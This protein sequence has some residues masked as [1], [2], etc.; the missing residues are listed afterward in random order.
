MK[1]WRV[2]A[3]IAWPAILVLLA[4]F[5]GLFVPVAAVAQAPWPTPPPAPLG[6][7]PVVV[8]AFE[9]IPVPAPASP[10]SIAITVDPIFAGTVPRIPPRPSAIFVTGEGDAQER[11]TLYV[12]AGAIDRTLQFTYEPLLSGQVPAVDRSRHIQRAFRLQTYD[13]AGTV[14]NR[15]FRYP[16]RITLTLSEEEMAV[17]GNDPA[18]HYLAWYDPQRKLWLPL[19]TTYRSID[20]TLLV[21]ILQ[22][23]LFA[24]IAEPPPVPK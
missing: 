24:L 8:P 5:M 12:D 10:G 22:P 11:V 23:G 17:A 18:R 2:G 6:S 13:T 19:V 14:L 7:F 9:I 15:S 16:L 21:R 1:I 3:L 4:L 20:T